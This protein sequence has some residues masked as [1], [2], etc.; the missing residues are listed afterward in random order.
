MISVSNMIV[1]LEATIDERNDDVNDVEDAKN[2]AQD[3][4]DI[5]SDADDTDEFYVGYVR[6][7][8]AGWGYTTLYNTAGRGREVDMEQVDG[9]AAVLFTDTSN[10]DLIYRRCTSN[11]A[12][13]NWGTEVVIDNLVV[14]DHFRQ[15]ARHR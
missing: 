9:F 1:I 3:D 6:H 7:N 13:D 15:S 8:G 12:I 4:N 2:S 5:G 10:N 14:K 11:T